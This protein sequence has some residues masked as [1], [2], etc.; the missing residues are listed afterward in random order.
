MLAAAAAVQ[1]LDQVVM[2]E[3][4]VVVMVRVLHPEPLD[5]PLREQRILAVAA[6]AE[7]TVLKLAVQA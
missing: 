6:V 1:M 2:V 3:R 7:T 5:P 4:A